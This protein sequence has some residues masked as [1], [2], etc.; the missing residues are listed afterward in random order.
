MTTRVLRITAAGP[1]RY[2]KT[3]SLLHLCTLR[4]FENLSIQRN[5]LTRGL[6]TGQPGF[7]GPPSASVRVRHHQASRVHSTGHRTEIP[8]HSIS[9]QREGDLEVTLPRKLI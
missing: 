2:P 6:R 7:S 8:K 9:P 1:C 5:T 4:Y 3:P